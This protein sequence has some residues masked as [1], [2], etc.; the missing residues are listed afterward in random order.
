MTYSPYELSVSFGS[1]V[2]LYRFTYL[3]AQYTWCSGD[4]EFTYNG[5]VYK[6]YPIERSA[7]VVTQV[8]E[9]SSLELTVPADNPISV[10]F[11]AGPPESTIGVTLLRRHRADDDEQY[12]TVFKG[13]VGAREVKGQEAILSCEPV[14]TSAKRV[15]L[16]LVYDVICPHSLY[17]SRCN[18]LRTSFQVSATVLSLDG[19]T[20][21]VQGASAFPDGWFS[22]GIIEVGAISRMINKHVGVGLTLMHPLPQESIGAACV[23]LPGCDKL[24][25]TCEL[26]YSNIAN[27]GGYSWLPEKNPFTGDNIFF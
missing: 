20:A 4:V 7:A 26:K 24:R 25:A 21:I 27:Y 23:L 12:I 11:N 13:R 19:V 9:K 15:G 6:P 2:E 5:N 3:S 16:R 8:T 10:L 18:V 14:S 17:D 1:P 22:Y